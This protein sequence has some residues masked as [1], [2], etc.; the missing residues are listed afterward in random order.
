MTAV[1]LWTLRQPKIFE[2]T[3]TIVVNPQSPRVNK[4]DEVIE[5]G[6]GS[7]MYMRDYYNTQLEVLTSFPLARA[8]VIQGDI[9]KFYD[10]LASRRR[11][12][13]SLGRETNRDRGRAAA[14][15]DQSRSA[16]R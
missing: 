3:S 13:I 11:F 2:A 14:H 9:V 8:T 5:L 7:V 15:D 16:Q 6:A 1:V 12:Q 4:D 10:R